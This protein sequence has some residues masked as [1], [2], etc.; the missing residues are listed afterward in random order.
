MKNLDTVYAERI[1]SEYDQKPA[2]KLVALKKLDRKAKL[3]AQ[4]FTYSFGV[5]GALIFGVGMCLCMGV[6]GQSLPIA[7]PLGI[8][9]GLIGIGMVSVNYPVYKKLLEQGKKKYTFEI[10]ELA[11]EITA[12]NA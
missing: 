11:K 3:P 5:A 4:I 12:E 10:M 7:M 9:T 8:V 6:I 1:A 2:S